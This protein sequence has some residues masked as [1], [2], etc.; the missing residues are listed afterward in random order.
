MPVNGNGV[1]TYEKAIIWKSRESSTLEKSSTGTSTMLI[2]M[3]TSASC[4]CTTRAS[5]SDTGTPTSWL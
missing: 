3:P 5:F 4:D 1:P 2:S